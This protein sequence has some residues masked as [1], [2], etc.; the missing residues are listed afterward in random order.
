MKSSVTGI[1]PLFSLA[2]ELIDAGLPVDIVNLEIGERAVA[3]TDKI[4][5]RT[6]LQA[7]GEGDLVVPL[8]TLEDGSTL[9]ALEVDKTKGGDESFKSLW[10]N[11]PI[12]PTPIVQPVEGPIYFL[13][14]FS[15]T[16]RDNRV[17]L[18]P[19]LTLLA[20]GHHIVVPP[21]DGS[22][23]TDGWW[24]NF[25]A[26]VDVAPVPDKLASRL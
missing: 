4:V 20:D 8:G 24:K 22:E 5:V 23:K 11:S 25:P 7:Y 2:E 26:D 10:K 14:R 3:R 9:I 6:L 17:D 12:P 18:G 21:K 19:G 13:L 1:G 16:P 15:G